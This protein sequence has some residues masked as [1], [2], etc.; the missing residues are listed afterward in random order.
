[1]P[2][3]T[4][5]YK[6]GGGRSHT[7]NLSS[8]NFLSL[9]APKENRRWTSVSFVVSMEMSSF[10]SQNPLQ[11]KIMLNI[12]QLSA[13]DLKSRCRHV[14]TMGDAIVRCN[15]SWVLTCCLLADLRVTRLLLRAVRDPNRKRNPNLKRRWKRKRN[16]Q[17]RKERVQ[18]QA[19]ASRRKRRPRLR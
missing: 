11:R 18:N 3:A 16:L 14:L 7:N 12:V 6:R 15:C 4:H 9:P 8:L 13:E 2:I 5:T 19:L 17:K 10:Y 1:M